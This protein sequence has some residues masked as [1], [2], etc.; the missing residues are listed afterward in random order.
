MD[1]IGPGPTKGSRETDKPLTSSFIWTSQLDTK[2]KLVHWELKS[3]CSTKEKSHIYLE[4]NK[5]IF[6][7]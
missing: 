7:S 2:R 4:E 1:L 5:I 6:P 3:L